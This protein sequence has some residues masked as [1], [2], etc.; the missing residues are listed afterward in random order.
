MC[1]EM[2][3]FHPTSAGCIREG[4][5]TKFISSPSCECLCIQKASWLEVFEQEQITRIS[6]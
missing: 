1:Q 4:G 3:P 6:A 5:L 2:I